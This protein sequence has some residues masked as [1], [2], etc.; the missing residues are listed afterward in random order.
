M[1]VAAA[2]APPSAVASRTFGMRICRPVTSATICGQSRPFEAPPA[3]ISGPELSTAAKSSTRARFTAATIEVLL[4]RP[5]DRAFRGKGGV[6]RQV[7]QRRRRVVPV[8][9]IHRVGKDRDDAVRADRHLHGEVFH[10]LIGVA[11]LLGS[12]ANL[13]LAEGIAEPARREADE[14]ADRL[15]LIRCSAPPRR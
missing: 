6:E 3:R 10:Q 15:G 4:D 12:A 13:L 9:E 7:Q 5:E 2:A 11:P 1:P 8:A 14:E